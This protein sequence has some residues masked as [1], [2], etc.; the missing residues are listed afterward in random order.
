MKE[1]PKSLREMALNCNEL[2]LSFMEAGYARRE[3]LYLTAA[4]ITQGPGTPPV[5]QQEEA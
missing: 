5:G 4:M 3:A 2:T 1:D